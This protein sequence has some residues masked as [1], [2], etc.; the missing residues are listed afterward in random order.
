MVMTKADLPSRYVSTVAIDRASVCSLD[1]TN[2]ISHM[3]DDELNLNTFATFSTKLAIMEMLH[4]ICLAIFS[5]Q[6]PD[7]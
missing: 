3:C 2:D 5:G 4:S 7:H 6:P 1:P